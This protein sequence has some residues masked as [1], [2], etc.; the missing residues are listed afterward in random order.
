MKIAVI[1]TG[2]VGLVTGTCFAESG[3]EVVC[4]DKDARKIGQL[5]QGRLGIR[6]D[7]HAQ[8]HD[9]LLDV[10]GSFLRGRLAAHVTWHLDVPSQGARPVC[11]LD[12]PAARIRHA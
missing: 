10:E 11:D 4:V 3:N 8:F 6:R 1:G 2:Y 9:R 7:G 12:T 5:E